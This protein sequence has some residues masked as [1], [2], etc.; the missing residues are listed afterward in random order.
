VLRL[1]EALRQA[2]DQRLLGGGGIP[3]RA[4]Q[5]LTALRAAAPGSIPFTSD[6]SPVEAALV[7][8][9]GYR[10]L[11]LVA[12]SAV[13]GVGP[14]YVAS[15]IDCEATGL[16]HAYNTATQLAVQRMEQEAVALGAHGVIG[17]RFAMVRREWVDKTVEVQ[18][19]GTAIAGPGKVAQAPWLSDLAG[20]EWWALHRA[21]YEPAGL[22][23]GHCAWFVLTTENDEWT[24]R[25]VMNQELGHMSRALSQAR[26]R[27]MQQVQSQARRAGAVG[28]VGVH[29]SRR[30]DEIRLTGLGADTAYE[31]EHHYLTF[32][33]IGTAI[34]LRDDAPRQVQTTVPV[35]SLREGRLTPYK[36]NTADAKFE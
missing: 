26:S 18:V 1:S 35:L 17:V 10:P 14:T 4:R 29:L 12:G 19:L 6:L 3:T 36:V 7:R 9:T 30:L 20:Q 16:S 13:Y 27:A 28:V 34:S 32:S 2:Q 15:L 5:R 8:R 31:R 23:Y 25:S 22:V 24:G 21:G 11:G 33:I